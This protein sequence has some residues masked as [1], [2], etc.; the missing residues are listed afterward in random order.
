M[1]KLIAVKNEYSSLDDIISFVKK[2]SSF[3]CSKEYDQWDVRTDA[4]GQME[5]CVLV[6][7]SGMHGVMVY[8]TEGS[9]INI[10]YVIPNKLMNAY[11]GKSQKARKSILE[12]IGGGI[13]NVVLASSQKKAFE[14]IVQ[15]FNKIVV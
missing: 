7:K 3:E 10:S 11:F 8:F 15:I 14:E 2:E 12:V 1:E 9:T 4:N 6:K 13:K 5:Q